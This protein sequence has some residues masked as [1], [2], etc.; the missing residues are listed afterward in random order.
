M[1][2]PLT[3]R[4]WDDYSCEYIFRTVYRDYQDCNKRILEAQAR[5]TLGLS[6]G[7]LPYPPETAA[8]LFSFA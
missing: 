3:I 5:L 2:R 6:D 4:V 8:L 1:S 7:L